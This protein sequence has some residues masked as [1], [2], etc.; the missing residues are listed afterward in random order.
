VPGSFGDAGNG[1]QKQ[2]ATDASARADAEK[3]AILESS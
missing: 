3:T 2:T 1:V